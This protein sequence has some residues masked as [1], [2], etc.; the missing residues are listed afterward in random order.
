MVGLGTW[1]KMSA[2][3]IGGRTVREIYTDFEGR[4]AALLQALTRG[5]AGFTCSLPVPHQ[6]GPAKDQGEAAKGFGPL[7]QRML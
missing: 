4:R 3:G 6:P 1:T 2:I 7:K 5:K